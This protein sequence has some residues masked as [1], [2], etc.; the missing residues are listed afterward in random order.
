M[1]PDRFPDPRQEFKLP[2]TSSVFT[3]GSCFARNIE[4]HLAL[5]G[6]DVPTLSFSVP[7][8]EWRARPNGILNKYTPASIYQEIA[9]A[10]RIH[11]AGEFTP[12]DCD[13]LRW[14]LP[15]GDV[16]DLQLGGNQPVSESRFLERRRQVFELFR[17]AFSADCVTLTL[18]LIE[19]WRDTRT[20]L[21]IQSAPVSRELFRHA[22]KFEFALLDYEECLKFAVGAIEKVRDQ[23][24]ECRI[25]VTTS[26]VPMEKTFTEDDVVIANTTSKSILRSVADQVSKLFEG[27]DYFPSYEAVMLNDRSAVFED[28]NLHVKDSFVGQIVQHLVSCY[29]ES[30]NPVQN[31]LQRAAIDLTDKSSDHSAIKELLAADPAPGDLSTDQLIVYLR[32]CW[33]L[34]ERT[35]AQRLAS[36]I[37]ERRERNARN[38]RAIKHIFPKIGCTEDAVRYAEAIL[39]DDPQNP[40]AKELIS[41][42]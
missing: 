24:P 41:E 18:G 9:W 17:Q 37:M 36:E 40:L 1:S 29:F 22:D 5:I 28:D 21:H 34:R 4:E 3:I 2:A 23:N 31:L 27:V 13:E 12:A 25:L 33:R 39:A 6:C 19:S 30:P 26:P 38:F 10:H 16:I 7:K 15:N 8:S 35:M 20:G 42:S 14:D 32:S 11:V